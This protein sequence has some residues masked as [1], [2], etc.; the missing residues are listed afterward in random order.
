MTTN[1][2][3]DPIVVVVSGDRY[4]CYS[5]HG[6][7]TPRDLALMATLKLMGGVNESVHPGTW[8][9]NVEMLDTDNAFITMDPARSNPQNYTLNRVV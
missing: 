9:F 3:T 4:D 7:P 1:I 8:H 2:D 5:L 6:T